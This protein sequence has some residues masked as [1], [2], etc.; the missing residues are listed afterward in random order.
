LNLQRVTPE[1]TWAIPEP[2]KP[3]AADAKPGFEVATIKPSTPGRPGKGI[4]FRGR[5]F[6]AVNFNVNDLISIG[7]GV[8]EKQI[9]GAPAWF[10]TELFDIDGVPDVEGQPSPKQMNIMIQK[11]LT[12]RFKLVF[13]HE[14]RELAVYAITAGKGGP[15]MTISASAPDA[16]Q[17]FFFRKLGALTV[18][19]QTMVDFASWM[20]TV[21]DR[22]VVDQSGLKDRYDFTLNWT[23]DDSQFAQFRGTGVTLPPPTDD[24][25]APPGLFTAIQE[26]LGMKLEA[27]KA[28]ADVL[29]IDSVEKPSAN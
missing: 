26:Q 14:K 20:Q 23:P 3:M 21:M 22:P 25:N 2:P 8:H 29:V 27:V 15:K 4:G 28:Q 16:P 10:G 9:I 1:N 7:Y 17:A 24:P 5:H 12:D 11:L 19:N 18:R 6:T 13:H